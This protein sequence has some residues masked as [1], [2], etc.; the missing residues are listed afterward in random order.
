MKLVIVSIDGLGEEILPYLPQLNQ[1]KKKG[2]SGIFYTSPLTL[3]PPIWASI[4]TGKT[5][6]EHGVFGLYKIQENWDKT[7]VKAT[8]IE[9]KTI[10]EY[11]YQRKIK[12]VSISLPMTYP[13]FQVNGIMV[14]DVTRHNE[15]EEGKLTY[16]SDLYFTLPP[17]FK[18]LFTLK[19]MHH[20]PG[21]GF[22][23]EEEIYYF[24]EEL[25]KFLTL[26]E[27]ITF[28]LVEKVD[29]DLLW[30][31][32]F[33]PDIIQHSLWNY[34]EERKSKI[35]FWLVNFWEK[36]DSCISKILSIHPSVG[37]FIFSTH[38]FKR[39]KWVL[40]LKKWLQ[41]N[42]FNSIH[43]WRRYLPWKKEIK[44]DKVIPDKKVLYIKKGNSKIY[45]RLVQEL[46]NLKYPTAST[47]VIKKIYTP[48]SFYPLKCSSY[49]PNCILEF[50]S[51]FTS[52]D[53]GY[54]GDTFL[55]QTPG[56]D[57]FIG[58]HSPYG[59]YVVEGCRY[60]K[61]GMNISP[62]DIKR[63]ILKELGK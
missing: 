40:N 51:F 8:D 20:F 62:Q 49:I 38:N 52:M 41:E 30:V 12:V 19:T 23:E 48:S 6:G 3:T 24:I 1:L 5:P 42:K 10:W 16:P 25:K 32:F 47:S 61:G 31:H 33:V 46:Y 57:F 26:K 53:G 11:L 7:E 17:K 37:K 15:V 9:G 54:F 45:N 58:T 44:E 18:S 28:F 2:G 29:W 56:K 34:I 50:N 59:V 60:F 14:S 63:I 21:E 39:A 4:F 55:T 43:L 13:S 35:H 27:E 36:L 22:K